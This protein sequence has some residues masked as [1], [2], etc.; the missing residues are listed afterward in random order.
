MSF[1][2]VAVSAVLTN[3]MNFSKTSDFDFKSAMNVMRV[4]SSMNVTKYLAP[5]RLGVFI[6]P[7]TSL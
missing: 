2:P 4:K 6:G 3:S 5:P 1:L 7:H